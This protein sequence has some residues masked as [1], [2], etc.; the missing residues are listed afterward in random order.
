MV[1]YSLLYYRQIIKTG[2]QD[3]D[4]KTKTPKTDKQ[5]RYSIQNTIYHTRS[6][7]QY[8]IAAPGW[9]PIESKIDVDSRSKCIPD[10]ISSIREHSTENFSAISQRYS[11]CFK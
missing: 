4:S 9:G 11:A 3:K 1:Y 2:Q 5:H 7:Y 6:R 8:P 10:F